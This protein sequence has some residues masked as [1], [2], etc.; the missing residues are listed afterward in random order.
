MGN[1]V[2]RS[3]RRGFLST[4]FWSVLWIV[5]LY[6]LNSWIDSRL[7]TVGEFDR[8]LPFLYIG[9]AVTY[10]LMVIIALT[11][12][13]HLIYAP[14]MVHTFYKDG[15]KWWKR[16]QEVTYDFPFSM[17]YEQIFF[18][19]IVEASVTQASI[20]RLLDTG[21]IKITTI[22]FTNGEAHKNTRSIPGIHDPF[23]MLAEILVGMPIN[24]GTGVRL[25]PATETT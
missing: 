13:W 7:E 6:Y 18:D 22:A 5:V 19:R 17:K 12:L 20:D 15:E 23:G 11:A 9:L 2:L 21:T 10:G 25:R 1:L 3:S 24:T 8:E 4:Y 14:L 16:L